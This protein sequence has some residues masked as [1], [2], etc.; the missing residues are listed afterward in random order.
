MKLR[1]LSVFAAAAIVSLAACGGG[2]DDVEGDDSLGVAV[3]T[4]MPAPPPPPDTMMAPPMDSM[5]MDTIADTTV[6]P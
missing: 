5:P 4:G 6:T 2:D 3:D 1:T